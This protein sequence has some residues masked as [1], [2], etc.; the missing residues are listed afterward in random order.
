MIACWRL[1]SGSFCC[2]TPCQ[3]EVFCWDTNDVRGHNPSREQHAQPAGV[4]WVLG[5][6]MHLQL[7][8]MLRL[9]G[10]R[11]AVGGRHSPRLMAGA[12]AFGAMKDEY[13]HMDA[14]VSAHSRCCA[15]L[16][17]TFR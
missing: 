9:H 6:Q 15:G 16:W 13:G 12:R 10:L 7:L 3:T 14:S 2:Q 11:S 4:A 8:R 5:A 17:L 1:S